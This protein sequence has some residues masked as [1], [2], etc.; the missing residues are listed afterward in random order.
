MFNKLYIP[1]NNFD[2]TFLF[3]L[4]HRIRTYRIAHRLKL[5]L[6]VVS[7]HDKINSIF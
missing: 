1:I 5:L 6:H 4:V 2:W 3:C 7:S